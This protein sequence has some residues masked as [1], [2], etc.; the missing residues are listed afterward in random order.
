MSRTK[1]SRPS[2]LIMEYFAATSFIAL[3]S[4]PTS[5]LL[6]LAIILFH[7]IQSHKN[8]NKHP[9][10][11]GPKPWP[12][13]GCLPTMLRNKPVYRWI[14]NL[15]KEMNTEIACVRLGNVHVIPVICPDIACEFLKS[16]DGTFAS[17]PNTNTTDLI[18]RGYLATI[19]SP[20]GDQWKKMR[21]VLMTHVLSPKK[22]QW[23]YSK[24]VEEGDHLVHYVYNQCKKSVH[25]GGIVNLRTAAQH[26]CANV[27]RKMTFNKRFFGEGMKDGGPGFEEEEYVDA[28]FCSLNH[29]Y[30]FCISDFL[31]S[32]IGL[33]LDGHEKVVMENLRIIN[34]YHDPIIDE[35]IQQ[36]QDGTRKDTEDWLD[37]LITLKDPNGKPLLSRDEIKA[38]IIEI[39]IAA[40]DNPSNAC[41]WA[42]AEM[43]NQP[44][45]LEKA[46]E[47]LDRV[48]GKERLV[49]ESDFAHLN[50]VK[51]CAREAFRLHPIA[52]FNPP[53]VSVADTTV[54]NYFIPKGSYVLLSRLG[55]GR[56]PKV[57]DEPLKFKPERH[58]NEM[59]KVVLTENN[60]RF[61]SFATGKRGCIGVTL[62]TSM[63]I[64]LF[65]RLL[66]AFTWSLPP[67]HSSIDLTIADDSMALA[68]PL[69]ALAK[70]RLPP[71]L[72]SGY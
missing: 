22:H 23:L 8:V 26:Y 3:I 68:K 6:V 33:D 18:T 2:C 46:I 72:Y 57:W 39:M 61:I 50:Y 5:V 54:A 29:I 64:M 56:N 65:A 36:W 71:H 25:Q 7:F 63:T 45:M 70:P 69:F 21:K 10:P 17:R 35:R 37:I 58:L 67:R 13:V 11:P 38:Q 42:F 12:I 44:E 66:Q 19:L 20:S 30:A 55:L 62:G 47:E 60:L 53:H 32:L 52:P 9:L 28:L 59:D 24:R 51:A 27:T 15:M 41:E 1:S 48:V 31:P 4:S 14:H 43:L 34:K 40:V 49:Q 16:Q